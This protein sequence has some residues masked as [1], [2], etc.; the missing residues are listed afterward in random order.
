[1][2]IWRLRNSILLGIFLA[3]YISLFN[4]GLAATE[5]DY[6][7]VNAETEAARAAEAADYLRAEAE[8]E[9]AE[10][11]QWM[12][13]AACLEVLGIDTVWSEGLIFP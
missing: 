8:A 1:M 5:A 9:A 13:A 2:S 12:H 6:L 7:R 10:L 11:A 4:I 3:G